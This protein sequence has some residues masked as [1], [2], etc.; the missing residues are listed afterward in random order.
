MYHYLSERGSEMN[1]T[2]D[3][4]NMALQK[5]N[6]CGA[7][8]NNF[9]SGDF[10]PWN[11]SNRGRKLPNGSLCDECKL[12]SDIKNEISY[13]KGDPNDSDNLSYDEDELYYG[14]DGSYEEDHCHDQFIGH[15]VIFNDKLTS[16]NM[17]NKIKTHSNQ[18]TPAVIDTVIWENK[19]NG[20]VMH[21]PESW[22][23]ESND[24]CLDGNKFPK[25]TQHQIDIESN[26]LIDDIVNILKDVS[27]RDQ[28]KIIQK[29]NSRTQ[30]HNQKQKG[31]HPQC[32]QKIVNSSEEDLKVQIIGFDGIVENAKAL[33]DTGCQSNEIINNKIINKKRMN[34]DMPSYVYTITCGN[35]TYFFCVIGKRQKYRSKETI[36]SPR[37]AAFDGTVMHDNIDLIVNIKRIIELSKFGI[38]FAI[39]DNISDRFQ[40]I[41]FD[42]RG[43]VYYVTCNGKKMR[44]FIDTGWGSNDDGYIVKESKMENI[45]LHLNG[46][47]ID[48]NKLNFDN[49][50]ERNDSFR[51]FDIIFGINFIKKLHEIQIFPGIFY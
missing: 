49:S 34:A 15:A 12:N 22:E 8:L 17:E 45:T 44:A 13:D 21:I 6:D 18:L 3:M 5:C 31:K 9:F 28:A 19:I 48:F 23:D 41:P 32:F 37:I 35:A 27:V 33:F 40:K 46:K 39:N 14:E 16:L 7:I 36:S 38:N 30:E 10:D 29:L 24:E 47:R 51:G 26:K 2:L 42:L 43:D 1:P 25:I 50:F 11:Y 4:S 20:N